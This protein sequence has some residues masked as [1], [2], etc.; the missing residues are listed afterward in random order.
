VDAQR[1]LDALCGRVLRIARLLPALT[2]DNAAAERRRLVEGLARGEHVSPRWTHKA[3]TIPRDAW[4]AIEHARELAE[5]LEAGPL[6][7][8]RLDE[9]EL[10]LAILEDLGQPKRVRPMAARRFGTGATK[11]RLGDRTMELRAVAAAILRRVADDREAPTVPAHDPEGGPSVAGFVEALCLQCQLEVEV[12]V[13]PRLVSKAAAG[14]RSIFIADQRFGHREARR[15]AVHEVLGHMVAAFNARLQPIGLFT[16]GTAGAFEDQEGVAVW[17]EEAAGL[18]DGHRL[19]VLAAR[20]LAADAMH[21]GATFGDT[22]RELHRD[23]G[24]APE[25]AVAI[26]ERAYRGGGVARDVGYLRGWLR[27]RSALEA[28]QTTVDELRIG[29]VGLEALPFLREL[30]VRGLARAPVY[31]PSLARSL[32]ATGLGTSF[33]TSPPS[34]VTSLQSPDAT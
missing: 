4:T 5:T 31:R 2:P 10:E 26:A 21:G 16:L 15:L 12:K 13:E 6:Y 19:R 7:L 27:V 32:G 30:R 3:E 33:E 25:D 28:R 24:F 20:V 14:E 22:A 34:F 17:L 9:L 23:H 18:L 8:A 29:K 11:V 1:Q